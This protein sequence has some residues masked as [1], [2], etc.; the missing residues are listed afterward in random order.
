M[1]YLA[2]LLITL[3]LSCLLYY[4]VSV[5][6]TP[7]S[8]PQNQGAGPA[9]YPGPAQYA[10][11]SAQYAPRPAQY[12]PGSAQY[13]PGPAQ[14]PGP[15]QYAP[16]PADPAQHPEPAQHPGAQH[17][18]LAQ[19]APG[20]GERAPQSPVSRQVRPKSLKRIDV[21]ALAET[22]R[23][24]AR[25]EEGRQEEKPLVVEGTLYMSS[26]RYLSIMPT[27]GQ[28]TPRSF[29]DL[30]RVG[31]GT[32]VLE[33]GGFYIRCGNAAYSYTAADLEQIVFQKSGLALI[34]ALANRAV[35]VFITDRPDEV[36]KYIKKHSQ[37]VGAPSR[38]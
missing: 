3:G 35:P 10:P 23:V 37:I 2:A 38:T 8:S 7:K 22:V 31:Q 16:G 30:K 17:P 19:Y 26:N 1:F 18:G 25:E 29:T 13:A 27:A 11:G 12:A 24:Y 4:V 32:L 6:L 14:H 33:G 34:P 28:K 20:P 9:Q 15:T 5:S 21:N 36:K